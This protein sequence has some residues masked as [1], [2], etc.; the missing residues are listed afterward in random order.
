MD[1]KK[2]CFP[3]AFNRYKAARRIR[4]VRLFMRKNLWCPIH[5]MFYLRAANG[6]LSCAKKGKGDVTSTKA[7][8]WPYCTSWSS[9]SRKRYMLPEFLYSNR[10]SV[11]WING[12]SRTSLVGGFE[13]M[14]TS[15]RI[16]PPA[17][18][19]Q[20][21]V[22]HALTWMKAIPRWLVVIDNVLSGEQVI[23]AQ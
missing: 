6:F 23:G 15:A 14:L 5:K 21:I 1:R 11:Y 19:N 17:P 2:R 7:S 3:S 16:T 4:L 18:Q 8:Q 13:A 22:K 12:R 9:R 10:K 20:S